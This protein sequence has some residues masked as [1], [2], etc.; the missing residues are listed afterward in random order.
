MAIY[1]LMVK[2]HNK[3][4]LKYLCQTTR[5]DYSNY[6]GSGIYWK[7][8]LRIHGK[9]ISTELI[10]EC[11][12]R[13]ELRE[14]G[15]YYSDLWNVVHSRDNTGRKSWAN[16]TPESGTGGRTREVSA[17][18]G[19]VTVKDKDD[20]TLQIDVTDSR[21]LSGE[22]VSINKGKISVKDQA[23]NALSVSINDPRYLSGELMPN[24]VGKVSVKDE[25][26][27]TLQVEVTDP[28]Y[29]SGELSH[30]LKGKIGVRDKSGKILKVSPDDPRYLSGNLVSFAANKVSVKDAYGNSFQ[31]STDD[32][33][34]LSG[35]LQF[36]GG[37]SKGFKYAQVTCPHCGKVGGG[38][39]M[40][41][42][43]F[44]KCS[45]IL[46]KA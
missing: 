3:T 21:Y 19:K 10:K 13:E 15:L 27:N 25:A 31:V 8:H 45:S 39:N 40:I 24:N 9:D 23:G 32:S 37:P 35:E 41:R 43:H 5:H 16:Q 14:W 28:R 2:T 17:N 29:L 46:R 4:G 44:D 6:K 42:F 30:V 7:D 34:Y 33:R 36:S 11:H 12:T 38:P 22:L 18:V 20:N 26:G 1:Y